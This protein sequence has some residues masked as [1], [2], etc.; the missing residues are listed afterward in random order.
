[1]GGGDDGGNDGD[2]D[3]G[4]APVA[5]ELGTGDETDA[6]QEGDDQRR[7]EEDAYPED[8]AGD[9]AHIAVDGPLLLDDRAQ[10]ILQ[11]VGGH[12]QHDLEGEPGAC[13]KEHHDAG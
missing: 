13:A 3:N 2:D 9:E 1:N 12:R 6:G 5:Q 8:D 11:E 4:V 10:E 7:L